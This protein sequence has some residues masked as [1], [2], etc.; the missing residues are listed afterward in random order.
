KADFGKS[1]VWEPEPRVARTTAASGKS[2]CVPCGSMAVFAFGNNECHIFT[3][4]NY[5]TVESE[6]ATVGIARISCV[7]G[8][9]SGGLRGPDPDRSGA[10]SNPRRRGRAV[11]NQP[12]GE[13]GARQC[14]PSS[15]RAN[16][17]R[18]AALSASRRRRLCGLSAQ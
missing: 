17:T 15:D 8:R 4:E 1:P 12:P 11:G 10:E 18:V 9:L 16:R 14:L 7:A 6:H 3:F 2:H 5:V 13:G